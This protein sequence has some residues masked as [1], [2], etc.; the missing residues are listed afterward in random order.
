MIHHHVE[1][2][3]LNQAADPEVD[4]VEDEVVLDLVVIEVVVD[5]DQYHRQ[6]TKNNVILAIVKILPDR[7]VLVFSI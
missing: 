3:D 5:H 2:D 1:D 6:N 7:D 4:P